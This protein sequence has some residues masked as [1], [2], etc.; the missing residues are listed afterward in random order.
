[1]SSVNPP[2]ELTCQLAEFT[3]DIHGPVA[4]RLRVAGAKRIEQL[5]EIELD[6]GLFSLPR[7]GGPHSRHGIRVTCT[8]ELSLATYGGI[9]K[10]GTLTLTG[11][12]SETNGQRDLTGRAPAARSP[13]AI[14]F[15][16]SPVLT[17]TSSFG[18]DDGHVDALR[19]LATRVKVTNHQTTVLRKAE[20]LPKEDPCSTETSPKC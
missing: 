20:Q 16:G 10:D 12:A 2:G 4:A 17:I 8:R 19:K 1:M 18:G 11:D 14:R 9:T 13:C 5:G 7:A 15:Q 6:W 3:A